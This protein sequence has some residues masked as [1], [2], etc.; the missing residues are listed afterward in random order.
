MPKKSAS[1]DEKLCSLE[2]AIGRLVPD[3]SS[4]ALGLQLDKKIVSPSGR[5]FTVADDG[6]PVLELFV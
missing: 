6:K 4:V 2:E 1:Q 5:P 3:G